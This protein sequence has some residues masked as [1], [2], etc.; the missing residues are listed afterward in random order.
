MF[1]K[2]LLSVSF[3]LVETGDANDA[4]TTRG[5]SGEKDMAIMPVNEEN[6]Q[7]NIDD[8][9]SKMQTPSRL[10]LYSNFKCPIVLVIVES[11]PSCSGVLFSSWLELS[12]NDNS[13]SQV[14]WPTYMDE[15]SC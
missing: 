6:Y 2:Y 4:L 12:S 8:M 15:G 14:A 10:N 7:L 13:F 1:L 5:A 11:D 3:C 9:G